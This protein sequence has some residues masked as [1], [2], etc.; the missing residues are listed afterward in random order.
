MLFLFT[1][2]PNACIVKTLA[3]MLL[4][5]LLDNSK[6]IAVCFC[7]N[8]YRVYF[9]ID[10]LVMNVVGSLDAIYIYTTLH[11]SRPSPTFIS[12]TGEQEH[13]EHAK[14]LNC[15]NHDYLLHFWPQTYIGPY[16]HKIRWCRHKM[17]N[18]QE[19]SWKQLPRKQNKTHLSLADFTCI[20]VV[21]HPADQT[22][23]N[24]VVSQTW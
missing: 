14:L 20:L 17:S 15:Y 12:R 8:L 18:E 24:A 3:F 1:I 11:L 22:L 19:T 21:F 4:I 16:L 6:T 7:S 13:T 23:C 2:D 9:K 5:W 10:L